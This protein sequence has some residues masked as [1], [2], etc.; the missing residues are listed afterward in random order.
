MDSALVEQLVRALY[1]DRA[2]VRSTRAEP[3]HRLRALSA[4]LLETACQPDHPISALASE[5]SQR[6]EQVA[7]ECADLFQRSNSCMEGRNGQLALHHHARHRLSDRKLAALT[8]VHNFQ[9]RRPD[10]RRVFMF[11]CS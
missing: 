3:R 10:H 11:R 4:Q 1:L 7:G 9:L 2:A 8:A 5:D 6:L